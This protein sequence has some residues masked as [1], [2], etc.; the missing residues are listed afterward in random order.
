VVKKLA[1]LLLIFLVVLLLYCS[2]F[3]VYFTGDDFFHFQVART[4]GSL[5]AF[6]NFFGF[7]PFE[8][9]GIAFYRPLFREVLY[10]IFYSIF[11]LNHLPFRFLSLILHFINIS[12]V[13]VLM[14]RLF[15]KAR[16]SFFVAFFFGITA[17]NMASLYYLAGGIQTLAAAMFMLFSLV[18][19]WRYLEKEKIR[20]KF[21]SFFAFLLALT[22]H[23]L[24][25]ATPF[26]LG[27]LFFLKEK[28]AGRVILKAIKEIWPLFFVLGLYLYLNFFV[29]GFSQTEPQYQPTFNIKSTLN[30]LVWYLAWSL[31]LPE[32]VIDF[33][34]P[35][36][37]LNPSL[38]RHWGNYFSLIF[39]T[40]FLAV[41]ILSAAVTY[42]F[43]RNKKTFIDR[44]F[45]LFVFWFPLAL[46]PV[47]F[48]PFHKSSHYLAAALP[49][50]WA[51]VG[52]LA[53]KAYW[54]LAKKNKKLAVAIFGV[55]VAALL[56]LSISSV[57][58]ADSTYWAASRGRLAQRLIKQVKLRYSQL[59]KGSAVYFT[60][61]PDYPFVAEDWGGTSKQA[62]FALSGSDALQ[63][64][65]QD[66]E[67]KVFYEDLGGV[68]EDFPG[69]KVF[70]LVAQ[71][72]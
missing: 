55:F 53:F 48:L 37:R 72:Q 7:H 52:F 13:Y 39:P 34:R 60:N 41:T 22:C 61:D 65:Y 23:E 62:F 71:I 32:M 14:Q 63:L 42:L 44:R 67:L 16:L 50:F 3:S 21:A 27:G 64:L 68:S 58:L 20:F 19:F 36:L 38:M 11:G 35:G 69:D 8:Q 70:P 30:T 31:G 28:D 49:A 33:V 45:W 5:R 56:L 24:A 9:R 51:A 12:L 10:N 1:P 29:I 4:D 17:A 40:F 46:A 6:I 26:L 2:I 47:L 18:I 25:V 15:A 57:R 54:L 66:F 59:P 43:L